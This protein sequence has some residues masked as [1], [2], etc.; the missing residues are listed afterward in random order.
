MSKWKDALAKICAHFGEIP[1]EIVDLY[2]KEIKVKNITLDDYVSCIEDVVALGKKQL[3]ILRDYQWVKGLSK[4][5]C[6]LMYQAG[7]YLEYLCNIILLEHELVSYEDENVFNVIVR[8]ADWI[9][10]NAV[11]SFCSIRKSVLQN[12]IAIEKYE[13]LFKKPY[14]VLSESELSLVESVEDAI[15]LFEGRDLTDEQASYLVNYFNQKYRKPTTAYE[16]ICFILQQEEE[17][18]KEM[19]YGLELSNIPYERIAKSRRKEINEKIY[20]LFQMEEKPEERVKFLSFTGVSVEEMEKDLWEELNQDENMRRA[21]IKYANQLEKI[22]SYTL[23]NII[24]LKSIDIYS[25]VIN[26]RL[27]ECKEYE[28]YVSS[29]TALEKQFVME[30]DKLN[31]L[32]PV[33]KRM[34]HSP[35]RTRTRDYMTKNELFMRKMIEQK[36]YLD[37][38]ENILFYVAGKQSVDLLNYVYENYNEEVQRLYFSK[39]N[40]FDGYDSAHRFCELAK[41]NSTIAEDENVYKNVKGKLI[42]P[43]LEGWFTKICKRKN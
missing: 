39:I 4:R 21:Y 35:Y 7:F 8:N 25:P 26:K 20:K 37:V 13:F 33:Y 23:K 14:P 31:E 17:I 36:A 12:Q 2:A 24:K 10:E 29:R 28:E 40:G 27:L 34:F 9:Q 42:N 22:P 38:G 15:N 30:E 41:E 5:V 19:F 6:E 43:G 18:A 16:I 3:Q 11:K 1:D 32:W